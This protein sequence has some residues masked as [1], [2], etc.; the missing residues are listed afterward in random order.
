MAGQA[1]KENSSENIRGWK[2]VYLG[3]LKYIINEMKDTLERPAC[4]VLTG[5]VGAGKT[6]FSKVFTETLEGGETL[7]PT[8]AVVSESRRIVH[9][10][11]Y[12]LEAAQELAHLEL[13][14]HA[15]EKD[16]FLVEWGKKYLPE[17]KRELGK[18]HFY[19]MKIEIN[20]V[21][22]APKPSRNYYLSSV[23]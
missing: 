23:D 1:G 19:E 11:F 4:L 12:R 5:E 14:L 13:A 3:D 22:G 6:A 20:N 2:K 10:D 7:S 8:Y 16:F 18:F 21:V 9:A 15:E 17:L